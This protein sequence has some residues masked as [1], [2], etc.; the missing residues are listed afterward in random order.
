MRYQHSQP[1][2]LLKTVDLWTLRI[3]S[4]QCIPSNEWPRVGQNDYTTQH[5][6]VTFIPGHMI[7]YVLQSTVYRVK[8][9]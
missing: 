8:F 7:Y 3:L 4:Q 9:Q 6:C 1:R 2:F 5:E